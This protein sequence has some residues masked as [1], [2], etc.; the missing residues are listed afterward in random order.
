ME[1]MHLQIE[2]ALRSATVLACEL[3]KRRLSAS[4][5]HIGAMPVPLHQ[6]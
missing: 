1:R 2:M 6:F 5:N 4:P 3:T